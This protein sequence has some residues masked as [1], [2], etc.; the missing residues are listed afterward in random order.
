VPYGYRKQGQ[1][2]EAR[3]AINTDLIPGFDVSEA[4]V[5]G[6]IF[7]MGAGERKSCQRIAD[8]LNRACIPCGSAANSGPS[9][10]GK[11][12]R[13]IAAVWRPSHVRNLVVNRTYMGAHI[14][15]K[16][17]KNQNRRLIVRK[18]PPIVSEQTFQA[19]QQVLNANR[20]IC[21]RNTR[22]PFLLR[23][24]IKCGLC[25][26]TFSGM[27]MKAQRE[28]YYRCNGRQCARGSMG[29]PA[30]N[31]LLRASMAIMSSVWFGRTSN[32]SCGTLA[33]F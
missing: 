3:I 26:L 15:G 11:R 18:V 17:T 27:R 7:R 24:L 12:N 13:K 22:E 16:R 1:K 20:I 9:K 10:D 31:A 4:D 29:F 19:A 8:H 33:T 6:T 30:R 21:S 5:V 2:R 28:H 14:F 25:G 23:G 32:P